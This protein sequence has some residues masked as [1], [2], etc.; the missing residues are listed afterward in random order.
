MKALISPIESVENG[1]RV[2]EVSKKIFEVALPFFWVS[3]GEDVVADSYWYDPS[4]KSIKPKPEQKQETLPEMF[5]T[6]TVVGA[7]SL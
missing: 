3:C 5:E 1:Y 2:A 6:Q 4:D 7:Q